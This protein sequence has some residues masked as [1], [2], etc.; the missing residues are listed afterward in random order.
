MK[1]EISGTTKAY[2]AGLFDGE[3]CVRIMKGKKPSGGIAY[4]LKVY[5]NITYANIL[6]EMKKQFGGNVISIDMSKQKTPRMCK[7]IEIGVMNPDKWKQR[8]NYTISGK[9]AWIFLKTIETYCKEK[10]TQVATAIEYFNGK[11]S[12]RGSVITKS[13]TERCEYY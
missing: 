4:S 3:G 11:R 8:Y 13:E 10:R 9:E 6:Y 5:F 2:F 1:E 12:Y 7:A